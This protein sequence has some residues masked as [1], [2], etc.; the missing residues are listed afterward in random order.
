MIFTFILVIYIYMWECRIGSEILQFEKSLQNQKDIFS[1]IWFG[2]KYILTVKVGKHNEPSSVSLVS[3]T[4]QIIEEQKIFETFEAAGISLI[5]LS[6]PE[7]LIN[8]N[9][10]K[11]L[12]NLFNENN[13]L[14][15]EGFCKKLEFELW[16]SI[17]VPA[18]PP[19]WL[20][21]SHHHH[22]H[23][24]PLCSWLFISL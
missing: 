18:A 5:W 11:I 2:R 7:T 22:H 1:L 4:N 3:N 24:L 8:A 21:P 13:N 15:V 12:K 23:H 14:T 10:V 17:K 20:N 19:V 6:D 9:K 16:A